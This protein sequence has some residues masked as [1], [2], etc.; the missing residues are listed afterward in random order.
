MMGRLATQYNTQQELPTQHYTI[1]DE[2]VVCQKTDDVSLSSSFYFI[3]TCSELLYIYQQ[4]QIM[5]TLCRISLRLLGKK[6]Q[7]CSLVVLLY[8][9]YYL[10]FAVVLPVVINASTVLELTDDIWDDAT[11]GKSIYVKFCTTSC[12]HCKQ[13]HIAWERL[14]DEFANDSNVVIGRVNCDLE[15][16]LCDRF[17]VLGTPTLLYGNP[18][19]LQEYGGDK[20]FASL[21]AWA[22]QVLVPLCS[23]DNMAACSETEKYFIESWMKL[24][25]EDIE[26][27]IQSVLDQEASV[28]KE[29]QEHAH[30]LQRQYDTLEQR[31]S[32][33]CARI[34]RNIKLLRSV[35]EWIDE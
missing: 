20:D 31:H 22:K 2:A 30:E 23:P 28:E 12:S 34:Q 3:P 13:M 26:E 5:A 9:Y 1:C 6:N 10:L 29:F 32:L 8:C 7:K 11:K 35:K 18:H 4:K 33:Y 25:L 19:D 17:H 24:R 21:N 16:N 14:G 15:Q 27:M